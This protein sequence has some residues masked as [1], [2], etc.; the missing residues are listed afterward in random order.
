MQYVWNSFVSPFF[1][2]D[3]GIGQGFALSLILSTIYITLI[4]YKKELKFQFLL[5]YL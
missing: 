1:K 3:V 5:F 4:F 2:A